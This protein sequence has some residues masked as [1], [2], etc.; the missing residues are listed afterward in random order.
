LEK[1]NATFFA[2]QPRDRA[3][4]LPATVVLIAILAVIIA[5]FV[6][7]NWRAI[8][9]FIELF[10]T[11]P[12]AANA[13]PTMGADVAMSMMGMFA[14]IF[15]FMIP[16]YF[17]VAAYEAACLRWMIRGEAPG[18][19]G[20]TFDNDMWRVYGI[21]WCWLIVQF[22]VSTVVSVVTMP[23]MFASMG[24]IMRN[25]GDMEAM[26]RWQLTVQLPL[27]LLQYIPMI[28]LG[29]RFGPAAATSVARRRFSPIEAWNVTRG[30]F[31]ELLGSFALLW[32]IW[33]G[34]L[35]ATSVPTILRLWPHFRNMS[36]NPTPES[37]EDYFAA[38]FA[39]EGLVW[40]AL[41]YSVMIFGGLLLSVMMYG[42]NARAA[43]AA[44]DEGKI[45]QEPA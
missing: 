15:L 29:V 2:L 10:Q 39:P 27:T 34:V 24:D 45:K 30:R 40:M 19:F 22:A 20:L 17:A 8:S 7:L 41:G 25:P 4:L 36:S 3:V 35:V 12:T 9:F 28:F 23:L 1:L 16:I 44:L 11:L 26:W 43:L 42:V 13:K 37:M 32:L 6:A 38:A 5:A 14:S 31:W 18:W 21:Y 33:I